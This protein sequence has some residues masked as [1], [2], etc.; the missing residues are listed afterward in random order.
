MSRILLGFLWINILWSLGACRPTPPPPFETQ[1]AIKQQVQD[2][3]MVVSAHP[4]ATQ[5]GVDILRQG[6]NAIDAMV[7]VHLALAVVY[8]RAGNLGGGGFLVYRPK[9]GAVETLDF[10]ETAPAQAHKDMYLDAQGNVQD[11]LVRF[12]ALASGIPGSVQGLYQAHERHGKL[13]W[14]TLVQPAV[15]LARQGITLPAREAEGLNQFKAAF[16]RV[17]PYPTPFVKTEPWVEG[18]V[19][20]QTDLAKVLERLAQ[21]GRAGFYEGETAQLMVNGLQKAGGIFTLEDLKN[22][23]AVWRDPIA[24]PYRDYTI[25]S[26]GPPSSGGAC[27]AELL[28][29]VEP[30]PLATWGYQHPKSIHVFVEAARRAYADRAE[31]LG[32]PDHY[33]VPLEA[34]ISQAYAD[35]RMA[36]FNDSLAT[37][38]DSIQ[39]GSPVRPESEQTTHYCIVDGM[40]NVV[41]VTTTINSNYGSKLV[42]E[43]AGFFMNNEMDDFSAKPGV[44]N[45]FGL[46]GNVANAIAPGKRMLSSMTPSIVDHKGQFFMAVGTPGGSKII[47]TVFQVITNVID[48]QLPL[49]EAVHRPRF[50]FQW[51]PDLLYHEEGAFS[52]ALLQQLRAMGHQPEER[53][54][55]G[56]VEAILKQPNGQLEGVA[57]HRGDDHAAG[58]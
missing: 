54:P 36:S 28:N 42:V 55:I 58:F 2:S 27:L 15:A 16:E 21:Q 9:E 31:H 24:I 17:N 19:L 56:Q 13:P 50:H 1:T 52:E 33:D 14:A 47:T 8:P 30:Y 7:A 38:S 45:Q 49:K 44:P 10:R 4:L 6:G 39:H 48:Y 26:M 25:Y 51:Y 43:G 22:Y 23:Q 11:S 3:G 5:V 32:D 29:M 53:L 34:L 40:G 12:G 20:V 57:D 37:P 46:L 18:D 41:S 35:A